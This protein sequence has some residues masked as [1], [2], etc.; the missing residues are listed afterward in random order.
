MFEKLDLGELAK[1]FEEIQEK[2]R[3][4]QEEREKKIYTAKSGGGMVQV[5]VNGKG[6]VVDIQIDDSLLEDKDSL[7]ILL[8]SAINDAM[9]MVEEDRKMDALQFMGTNLFGQR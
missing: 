7:Q 6:E 5:S 4:L 2:A 3:K 1:A 9:K 8:L